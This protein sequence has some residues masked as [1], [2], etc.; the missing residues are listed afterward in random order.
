MNLYFLLIDNN[1]IIIYNYVK[2]VLLNSIFI[3]FTYYILN[4]N[5]YI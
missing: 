1:M 2:N 4:E 5:K 3:I